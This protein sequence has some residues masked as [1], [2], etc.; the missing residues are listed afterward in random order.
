MMPGDTVKFRFKKEVA[1]STKLFLASRFLDSIHKS[2]LKIN[3][4]SIYKGKKWE[5]FLIRDLPLF[6][7]QLPLVTVFHEH[8]FTIIF[9]AFFY[10]PPGSSPSTGP[11]G[12]AGSSLQQLEQMVMPG[13]KEAPNSTSPMPPKTPQSPASMRGP[14]MSPQQWQQPNQQG[15]P[16]GPPGGPQPGPQQQQQQQPPSQPSGPRSK[17]APPGI[18]P[19]MIPPNMHPSMNMHPGT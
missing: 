7:L 11:G 16:G 18:R 14:Q 2:F 19:G 12:G 10:S 15:Q 4:G 9:I 1:N 17:G 6:C 5:G 8:L 13:A 3:Y